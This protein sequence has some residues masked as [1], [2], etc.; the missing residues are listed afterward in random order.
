MVDPEG[1]GTRLKE[2]LNLSIDPVGVRLFTPG[3]G[4]PEEVE[5]LGEVNPT[6]SYCHAVTSAARGRPFFGGADKLGCLLGTSVLGLEASPGPI[7]ERIVLEKYDSGLY[8]TED[9]SRNSVDDTHRIEPGAF[10]RVFI[11]PLSLMRSEPHVVVFE[12][13]PETAMW[14]FYGSGFRRGGPRLLHQSGG[15]AGGCS[16]V[17]VLPVNEGVVNVSFL[18]LACRIKSEIPA[19]HLLLG[20]PGQ[21][22]ENLVDNLSRMTGPLAMLERIKKNVARSETR[23]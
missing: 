15:V 8:E 6:K 19:E 23:R 21:D 4:A 22:L 17:T 2:L 10:D 7:L 9:A 1:L 14:I 11:A 16:D 13:T 18:G 3:E 20:V 5:A 12:I